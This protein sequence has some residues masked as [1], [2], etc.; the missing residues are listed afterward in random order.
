[1]SVEYYKISNKLNSRK[2]YKTY[3]CYK[4]CLKIFWILIFWIKIK[5]LEN[6]GIFFLTLFRKLQKIMHSILL[7]QV[8]KYLHGVIIF[9]FL[10]VFFFI[11]IKQKNMFFGICTYVK[12]TQMSAELKKKEFF[13]SFFLIQS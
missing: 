3:E 9:A 13:S 12:S 5:S 8:Y 7:F 2:A 11:F 6:F 10:L 1:M 4:Y